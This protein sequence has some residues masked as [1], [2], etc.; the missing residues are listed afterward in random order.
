VVGERAYG[1]AIEAALREGGAPPALGRDSGVE[2]LSVELVAE[3]DNPHDAKAIG[4]RW[5]NR[6]IGFLSRED[7]VWY[8][9]PVQRISQVI[10]LL[11][12][13]PA[14]GRN[15]SCAVGLGHSGAQRKKPFLMFCSTT[16]GRLVSDFFGHSAQRDSHL[17]ERHGTPVY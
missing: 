3:P 12:P 7:P 14:F 11:R 16:C 2:S 10:S 9:Q 17:E 6:V 15:Q 13:R 8:A 4:V 5:S 1:K